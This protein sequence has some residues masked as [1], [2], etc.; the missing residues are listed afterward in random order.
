M[1]KS[2]MEYRTP[3]GARRF[4]TQTGSLKTIPRLGPFAYLRT[5]R[6]PSLPIAPFSACSILK[7]V[8]FVNRTDAG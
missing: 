4:P 5:R 8:P 1:S 7:L 6:P 3:A 2:K